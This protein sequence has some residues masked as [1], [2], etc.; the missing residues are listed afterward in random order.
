M[1]DP[2]SSVVNRSAP[3]GEMN[4]YSVFGHSPPSPTRNRIRPNVIRSASVG[5]SLAKAAST[6]DTSMASAVTSEHCG[7][8]TPATASATW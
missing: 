6:A 7:S 3:N 8:C 2:T 5:A 4:S 1:S